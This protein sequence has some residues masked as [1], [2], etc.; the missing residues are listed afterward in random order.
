ML[1]P[2]SVAA[3]VFAVHDALPVPFHS[4]AAINDVRSHG[5]VGDRWLSLREAILLTNRQ[6]DESALSVEE[7]AQLFGFGS[8]IAWAN[9]DARL[10]PTLVLERDL[11]EILDMPHGFVLTGSGGRPVIDLGDTRGIV[12]RSEFVDFVNLTLRG[13]EH[14]IHIVQASTLYGSQISNCVF[15]SPEVAGLRLSTLET[16][17]FGRLQIASCRF[18][19][20]PIGLLL[21]DAG[22]GRT[23]QLEIFGD[24]SAENCGTGIELRFGS[25]GS[26]ALYVF[27]FV[28]R[29]CTDA[30]RIV[31]LGSP[32][33]AIAMDMRHCDL[34]GTATAFTAAGSPGGSFLAVFQACDFAAPSAFRFGP[35]GSL[36]DFSLL[37]SRLSGDLDWSGA[38]S[39]RL[40]VENVRA[41]AGRWVAGS[42]GAQLTIA[43]SILDAVDLAS[44]GSAPLTVRE[45]RLAGGS[46]TGLA[47]APITVQDGHAAGTMIGAN[48]TV[49]RPLAQA[50]LGSF[51]ASPREPPIGTT[52][53]LGVDLPPGLDAWLV[54]GVTSESVLLLP[55]GTRFYVD[56]TA[57]A[58]VPGSFSGQG[59][60][61]VPLPNDPAFR[62][63]DLFFSA[64]VFPQSGMV[65]PAS[66]VPPGRR[67]RI[68]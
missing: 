37:D 55:D 40:R 54:F 14:G 35:L 50:Q 29:S 2:A 52:L 19:N 63:L 46:V 48:V 47:A 41:R 24:S 8:D 28:A 21:H 6:L 22:A 9:I 58:I 1:F 43:S 61:A 27:G 7:R 36:G 26:A 44:S 68:R 31:A 42:T 59:Q 66:N 18:Q 34:A 33:R 20:A 38:A 10:I 56:P 32:R 5:T 3:Q 30:L 15:E 11:P 4:Q 60:L 62:G 67:V 51:D 65:A 25:G 39:G 45:S 16:G 53:T 12:A 23:T 64:I 13:G 57:I 17:G 49:L